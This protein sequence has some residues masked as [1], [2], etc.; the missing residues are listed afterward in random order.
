M[1]SQL[2]N[3]YLLA[4][5]AAETWQYALKEIR[6]D[7]NIMD[8]RFEEVVELLEKQSLNALEL[9]KKIEAE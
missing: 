1:D 2:E 5:S 6:G 4:V 3:K 7:W 8:K 9:N